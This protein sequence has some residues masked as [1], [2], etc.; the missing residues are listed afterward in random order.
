MSIYGK[1]DPVAEHR[2]QFA[3]KGKIEYIAMANTPNIAIQLSILIL[4][5][6]RYQETM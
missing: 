6:S 2:I 1:L 4:R 3:F 5:Y